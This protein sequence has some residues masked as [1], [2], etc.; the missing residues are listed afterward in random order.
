MTPAEKEDRA[1]ARKVAAMREKISA[2]RAIIEACQAD[3]S[4]PG[5]V[6]ENRGNTGNWC[7]D[8]DAYWSEWDCPNCG[9]HWRTDQH[10]AYLWQKR[11]GEK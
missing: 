8:D 3:C 11:M 10:E 9:K 7:P 5:V 6:I 1:I 4:H 2:C